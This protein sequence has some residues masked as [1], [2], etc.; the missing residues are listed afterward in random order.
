MKSYLVLGLG[1]FGRSFAQTLSEHGC[2]VLGVDRNN[3]VVQ[4]MSDIITHVVCAES[5]NEEFLRS[6]GVNNF[7]AAIVAMGGNIQASV[8]TTV[9]LKELGAKY[10][11]AKAQNDLHAKVLYKVGADRVVFPERDMGIKA[12]NNMISTKIIDMIELSPEY[13]IMEIAIPTAWVGK[14]IGELAIR[15]K[16][17]V[18][19]LAIKKE[20]GINASPNADARF[21][22]KDIAAVMG[23]NCYLKNLQSLK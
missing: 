21:H 20:T 22:E 18:N 1:R 16:Y 6:V 9:L 13:S 15:A 3:Q 23:K 2:D 14:T 10:V 8:L 19:V 17:G 4:E 7:D 5:S 12:A 11:L